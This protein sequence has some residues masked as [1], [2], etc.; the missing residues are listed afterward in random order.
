M[1]QIVNDI[2]KEAKW[3]GK[4]A[5][6]FYSEEAMQKYLKEH[7]AADRSK[8]HVVDISKFKTPDEL[9][10]HVHNSP[11]RKTLIDEG[12]KAHDKTVYYEGDKNSNEYK[13]LEKKRN[14]IWKQEDQLN[15]DSG[16]DDARKKI[17]EKKKTIVD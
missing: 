15:A 16:L 8:H 14:E 6:D 5:M 1:K 4:R 13:D 3:I 7:P 10:T 2:V 9:W 17:N 12:Q 11:E